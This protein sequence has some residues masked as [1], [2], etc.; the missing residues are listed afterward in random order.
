MHHHAFWHQHPINV[1]DINSNKKILPTST[2]H[3]NN[4]I[5]NVQIAHKGGEL[6]NIPSCLKPPPLLLHKCTF[7]QNL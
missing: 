6:K 2:R 7:E 5:G 1:H 3:D 4:S